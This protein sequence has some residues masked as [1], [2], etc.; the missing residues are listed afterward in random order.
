MEDI[1]QIDNQQLVFDALQHYFPEG[2]DGFIPGSDSPQN[3]AQYLEWCQ[4]EPLSEAEMI[5]GATATRARRERTAAVREARQQIRAQ[6]E[7]LP[8]WL[9]GPYTDRFSSAER[10]LD[11][12]DYDAAIALIEYT[13]AATG[14]D[15]EQA[16]TFAMV[17]AELVAGLDGLRA[18][19]TGGS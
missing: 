18:L 15:A 3:Y 19:A 10:L 16:Q 2:F 13:A 14:Y 12:R 11:A 1:T 17:R 8:A 6:W 7:S 5:A 9:R 4:V